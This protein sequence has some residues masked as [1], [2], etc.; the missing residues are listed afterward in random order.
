MRLIFFPLVLLLEKVLEFLIILAL[1]FERCI[2]GTDCPPG[3]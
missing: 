1:Y 2:E 3:N